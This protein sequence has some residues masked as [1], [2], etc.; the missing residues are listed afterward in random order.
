VNLL[1][2]TH[3][4]LWLMEDEPRFGRRQRDYFMS[5]D[6]LAFSIAS[7]WEVCLKSAAGKLTLHR[8]WLSRF[9]EGFLANGIRLLAVEKRHC[10]QLLNLPNLHG[11]PFD[12]M[13]IAQ[14]QVEQLS[15]LTADRQFRE[16][17]VQVVW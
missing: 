6:Q 2:D 9:E 8:E 12:R 15:I 7:Y 16:Y 4:F 3:T 13:L 10:Q 5:A 11:D 1:L 14:A 17:D